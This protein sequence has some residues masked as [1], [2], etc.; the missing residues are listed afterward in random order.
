M[1]VRRHK[2]E[3]D[4]RARCQMGHKERV[5]LTELIRQVRG[6]S[7]KQLRKDL[8][9]RIFLPNRGWIKTS[10]RGLEYLFRNTELGR[11]L[12]AGRCASVPVVNFVKAQHNMLSIITEERLRMELVKGFE[13]L[14][15]TGFTKEAATWKM[16]KS[17]TY[18][19]YTHY[20]A[21]NAELTVAKAVVQIVEELHIPCLTIQ[22][23]EKH[24]V[25]SPSRSF[26]ELCRD[27]GIKITHP[28][29]RGEADLVMV[30]V[31]GDTL[32]F[33]F[34]EV[35]NGTHF[36]WRSQVS[37]P[38]RS[39]FEGRK[40]AW[41]QLNKSITF[42]S[43]L[44]PAMRFSSLKAFTA[45]PNMPKDVLE[46]HLGASCLENVLCKE[47]FE[48]PTELRRKLG[49]D[50]LLPATYIGKNLLCEVGSLIVG[51]A[52]HA[53]LMSR[54]PAQ[55]LPAEARQL[56]K[57][58]DQVDKEDRNTWE[59]L[60]E[61]QR[62]QLDSVRR[63]GG[64]VIAIEGA[65]GS[66]KTT[67]WP[68]I[69]EMKKKEAKEETGVEPRV[70][71][72]TGFSGLGP[73]IKTLQDNAKGGRVVDSWEQLLEEYGLQRIR[74][75]G[76][77][78][79][80]C[81]TPDEIAAL[82]ASLQA[83]DGAKRTILIF[84]EADCSDAPEDIGQTSYDWT[85]L[86]QLPP[87]FTLIII[88]NPG[89]YNGRNLLLPPS[90]LRLVLGVTY[91]SSQ[92]ISQ[93][94]SSLVEA[95]ELEAPSSTP[96]TEVVGELPTMTALGNLGKEKEGKIRF[97]LRKMQ[98]NMGAHPVTVIIASSLY[99]DIAELVRRETA[100]W[101]GWQVM[102]STK[103]IGA[104]ADRVVVITSGRGC[105]E[106]ISRAKLSLGIILCSST[107]RTR[108]AYNWS[109]RGF[110]TAAEEG[111]VLVAIPPWHPEVLKSRQSLSSILIAKP[112][113][114]SSLRAAHTSTGNGAAPV[115][116]LDWA[117]R[118]LAK[119]LLPDL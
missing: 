72:T 17:S 10:L 115:E 22:S 102:K 77:E 96:G 67:I 79:V 117:G 86:Q 39:I 107:E 99:N 91:R 6:R 80:C 27:A 81:N 12:L 74:I 38:R 41:F 33:R 104:E 4:L 37:P 57:E 87:N 73:L 23:L 32:A 88:F 30:L 84:E 69:L 95:M 16:L 8:T 5:Q 114:V 42:I 108:V 13:H 64:N 116:F 55:V 109:M 58:M 31:S 112:L 119:K 9:R 61:D 52:S 89:S 71:I 50:A 65:P 78:Y 59:L 29:R 103:M 40:S 18:E 85:A 44:F 68:K 118:G 28:K 93:L 54:E 98:Q 15:G 49:V 1:K 34:V 110:R 83:A 11:L 35:K 14:T 21:T 92:R 105:L 45:I 19:S 26:A 48:N 82:A 63:H 25:F 101:R 36:P 75:D 106:Q 90:C 66:G 56:R 111:R 20:R 70:L 7:R 51:P 94:H 46:K 97:A 53:H 60:D 100:G 47:H 62:R 76:R 43:Q 113:Q 3:E 24:D 2:R